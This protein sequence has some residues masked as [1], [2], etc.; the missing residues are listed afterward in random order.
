MLLIFNNPVYEEINLSTWLAA[1]PASIV[2]AN[3][4]LTKKG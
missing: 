1:N 4:G 3:F 2:E